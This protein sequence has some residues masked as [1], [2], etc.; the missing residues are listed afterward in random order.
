MLE[1]TGVTIHCV[2]DMYDPKRLMVNVIDSQATSH[3]NMYFTMYMY[4]NDILWGP[5]NCLR[6]SMA[7]IAY[8]EECVKQEVNRRRKKV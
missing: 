7:A 3:D 1:G 2:W 6:N 5:D 4:T 8:I